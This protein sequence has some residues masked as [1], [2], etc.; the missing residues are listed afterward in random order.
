MDHIYLANMTFDIN[1][2]AGDGER[3]DD[4]P[5]E[6]DVD[7]TVDLKPAGESDDLEKTVDYGA[8]FRLCQQV[9][10]GRPYRLLEALAERVAG[11]ILAVESGVQS[12]VVTVRKP[13]VPIDGVLD[14]AGVRVERS[15]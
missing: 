3:A 15:R 2:G 9:A 6:I 11:E 14:Y 8:V 4:Q 5:I 7:M 10:E 12:V 13:G 1:I